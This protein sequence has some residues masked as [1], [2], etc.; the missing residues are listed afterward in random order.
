MRFAS[1]VAAIA[2]LATL[3]WP[4]AAQPSLTI[5]PGSGVF[6]DSQ[7]SDEGDGFIE[8]PPPGFPTTYSCRSVP[9]GFFTHQSADP[10]GT[11]HLGYRMVSENAIQVSFEPQF[12][13]ASGQSLLNRRACF[14]SDAAVPPYVG[15]VVRSRGTRTPLTEQCLNSHGAEVDG[16]EPCS[17]VRGTFAGLGTRGFFNV[18]TGRFLDL[19][20]F[21]DLTGTDNNKWFEGTWMH[22]SS[23]SFLWELDGGILG[24][25]RTKVAHV[26]AALA[27]GDLRFFL[28]LDRNNVHMIGC[29]ADGDVPA[30]AEDH[31]P[32]P[33]WV[34]DRG[35]FVPDDFSLAISPPTGALTLA[36][37][38]DLV[39][40]AVTDGAS[41]T[42]VT[43]TIDGQD[44]SGPLGACLAPA[45]SLRGVTGSILAC[46]GLAGRVLAGFFGTGAHTLA[47]SA[48]LSDGRTLSD[49][50]TWTIV[51]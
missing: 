15:V 4:V 45:G 18:S 43:G 17:S 23:G 44:V 10:T 38:F 42:R 25:L 51:P 26:P 32:F 1:R 39:V 12:T 21:A 11:A 8:G 7:Y 14:R 30:A 35:D 29:P 40:M 9:Q 33:N 27:L 2:L 34:L 37:S 20:E 3:P 19:S 28:E 31:V 48:T 49:S 13:E 47:V 24:V 50:A 6:T 46:R 41:I 36:Q 16:D 22:A 5:S